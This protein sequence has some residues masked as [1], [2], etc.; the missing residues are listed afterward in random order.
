MKVNLLSKKHAKSAI[1]LSVLVA[2]SACSSDDDDD[3]NNNDVDTDDVSMTANQT[4]TVTLDAAQEVPA[5]TGVPADA[6]GTGDVT[7]DEDGVVTANVTVSGLSGP[8]TMAHI[9]RGF[10]GQ[11]GPILVALFTEDGGTTWTVADGEPALTDDQIGAF[12]RGELYFNVH[13]EANPSGEIRGQIDAG[14]ATT[15]TVRL[16]N[17]STAGT[18]NV[19]SDTENPTQAVPMSPG[20][21]IVHRNEEDSPILQERDAANAGLEAVAEDG[22]VAAFAEAV[23]GSVAFTTPV[24]ATEPGPIGPGGAYEFTFQAVDGDKLDLALMFIPSNDW[25]FSFVDEENSNSYDLFENGVPVEG[26]VDTTA[27]AIWDAG[28]EL[29]EEPGAGPNQVQRQDGP[30]VGPDDTNTAVDTLETRGQT[31]SLNGEVLQITVTAQ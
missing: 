16:D 18:L 30:N 17:L 13:T 21:F 23:P 26:V 9:H 29:D 25:F 7:V 14:N 3:D 12:N 6:T 5:P 11:A 31:V 15:F 28:T 10:A 2:L 20:V 27:F 24:D 22:S 8:A 1:A 19:A 4:V